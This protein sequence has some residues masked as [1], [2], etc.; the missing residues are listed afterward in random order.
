[1]LI[2]LMPVA[3]RAKEKPDYSGTWVLAHSNGSHVNAARRIVVVQSYER[4]RK[5]E[6]IITVA[7]DRHSNSGVHS[8]I[9]TVGTEGGEFEGLIFGPRPVIHF[10]TQWKGNRLVID[11]RYSLDQIT[12]SER[13]EVWALDG[14]DS[15]AIAVAERT[16]DGYS[17]TGKLVYRRER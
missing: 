3:A 8:S 2:A 13:K 9:Y 1:M 4:F 14:R 17:A 11:S 6:P 5:E 10:S 7:V 12:Y 16:T 15:L